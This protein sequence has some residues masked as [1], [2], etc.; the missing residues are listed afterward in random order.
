MPLSSKSSYGVVNHS[1]A[2]KDKEADIYI[3]AS[4]DL[5]NYEREKVV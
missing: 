1:F 4:L 2:V 5:Q 3:S